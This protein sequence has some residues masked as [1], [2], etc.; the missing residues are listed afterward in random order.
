MQEI[1]AGIQIIS[2][3]GKV[4]GKES[5]S[6]LGKLQLSRIARGCFLLEKGKGGKPEKGSM[7]EKRTDTATYT[8]ILS[9]E[10]RDPLEGYHIVPRYSSPQNRDPMI[11]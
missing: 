6:S 10:R 1:I 5:P 3:F 11:R 9:A 4:M 2:F 8:G 7:K